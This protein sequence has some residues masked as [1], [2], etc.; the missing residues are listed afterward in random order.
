M[1]ALDGISLPERVDG[2]E[3]V[4]NKRRH[5]GNAESN[6]TVQ[7]SQLPTNVHQWLRQVQRQAV[8]IL[9]SPFP[10]VWAA[11]QGQM[12]ASASCVDGAMPSPWSS[13]RISTHAG[14]RTRNTGAKW[15][16]AGASL[17]RRRVQA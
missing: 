9:S 10:Q 1:L 11:V 17:R 15:G 5:V 8:H 16:A 4:T 13:S 2:N 3:Q 14:S 12:L 7:V 6:D